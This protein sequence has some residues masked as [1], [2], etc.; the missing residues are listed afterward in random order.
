M[1]SQLKPKDEFDAVRMVVEILKDFSS[2]DQAR[3]MRWAQ[4]KLGFAG[5]PHSAV[6]GF[7]MPGMAVP[8]VGGAASGPK[9]TDISSFM[10]A[11]SPINDVQ[12]AT[13]VAYYYAFEAPEATRK[14]EISASDLL[15]AARQSGRARLRKPIITLHNTM[16]R[17][18]LD[19]GGRGTF[20]INPVGENLVA[21][22]LPSGSATLSPRRSRP[23][24]KKR[25][26]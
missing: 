24:R 10:Q 2:D 26:T 9:G 25:S 18:Y 1:S 17:G 11:K 7:A 4:E 21:M 19:K 8:G 22:G 12:F 14:F 13:A 15:E 16:K 23:S 20:K 5:G 3:V 6:P